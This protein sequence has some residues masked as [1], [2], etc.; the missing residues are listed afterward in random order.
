[1]VHCPGRPRGAEASSVVGEGQPPQ[2]ARASAVPQG[3]AAGTIAAA[4]P[5]SSQFF[6]GERA[7]GQGQDQGAAHQ[8]KGA[9]KEAAGKVVGD[10]K[11][12]AEG[13]AE[14]MRLM[15]GSKDAVRW[16]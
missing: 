7:Y 3:L 13:K 15:D 14:K 2:W 8:A 1:M 16:K 12:E 11:T 5:L 4:F 6:V 10:A 9:V